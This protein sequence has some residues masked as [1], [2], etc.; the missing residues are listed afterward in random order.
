MEPQDARRDL[1]H[2][3][4]V[5]RRTHA[6]VDPHLFHAVHWGLL[7]LI[8]YPLQNY[9]QIRENYFGMITS[10]SAALVVGFALSCFRELRL[11]RQPRLPAENT[12]VSR[13]LALVTLY[14]IGTGMILSVAAPAL[15]FIDG[16]R[17]GILWGLVY[18]TLAF[19]TGVIY[20]RSFLVAGTAIF[21]GTLIAMAF[22]SVSG[23]I[24]GPV[25]GLCMIIPG[26]RAE[27]RVRLLTTENTSLDLE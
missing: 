27:A 18:A 25:M 6:R 16:P 11:A 26:L 22:Q 14:C 13:Q 24:L 1:D 4:E 10:G 3:E 5:L 2:I 9:L 19:M 7:V 17:V 12:Y 21:V 20:E 15:Q 23:Y 8:M